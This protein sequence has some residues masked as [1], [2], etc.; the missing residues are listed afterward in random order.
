MKLEVLQ[1]AKASKF[2]AKTTVPFTVNYTIGDIA[3]ITAGLLWDMDKE[4]ALKMFNE[5]P[6]S[7]EFMV[8]TIQSFHDELDI[9]EECKIGGCGLGDVSHN[10]DE[11]QNVMLPI[12]DKYMD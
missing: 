9:V 4:T 6:Q 12:L 10:Y 7:L 5:Y 1:E 11:Y 2:G 8:K 3:Y